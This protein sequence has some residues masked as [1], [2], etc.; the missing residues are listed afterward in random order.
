MAT[1]ATAALNDLSKTINDL[2][3]QNAELRAALAKTEALLAKHE[4]RDKQ[5][6]REKQRTKAQTLRSEARSKTIAAARAAAPPVPAP[7]QVPSS[8]LTDFIQSLLTG[9][10]GKAPADETKG[11]DQLLSTLVHTLMA[12]TEAQT[13]QPKAPTEAQKPKS[14]SDVCSVGK[15]TG[16]EELTETFP[17]GSAT[18]Q[19]NCV[20]TGVSY[21]ERIR[22]QKYYDETKGV[23][24]NLLDSLLRETTADVSKTPDT[25]SPQ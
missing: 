18:Y 12:P 25:C 22:G 17:W 23:V 19:Q 24:T 14:T 10:S 5:E 13:P 7:A 4:M 1:Y 6:M 11:I 21:E 15:G 8:T 9:A 3:T 16:R 2:A 20:C